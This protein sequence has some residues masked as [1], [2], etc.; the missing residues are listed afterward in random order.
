MQ[1]HRGP[2]P[3]SVI[4]ERLCGGDVAGVHRGH[5]DAGP[6]QPIGDGA[7]DPPGS[8]RDERDSSVGA[9]Y[10]VPAALAATRAARRSSST[11]CSSVRN[12][13]L[14]AQA[15]SGDGGPIDVGVQQLARLPDGPRRE[16]GE[17]PGQLQRLL[18]HVGCGYRP[19]RQPQA[20]GFGAAD[21][22]SQE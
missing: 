2:V 15:Q 21:P 4:A 22:V 11:R 16:R 9:H 12:H 5:R 13:A 10:V 20:M 14:S 1:C 7:A 8:A 3:R 19:V 17:A 18:Q 6:S